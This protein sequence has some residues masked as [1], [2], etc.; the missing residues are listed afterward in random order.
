MSEPQ[1]FYPGS[2]RKIDAPKQQPKESPCT[3]DS[4]PFT[5]W[6]NRKPVEMFAIGAVCS[7]LGRPAV[8]IRLW[9]RQGHLPQAPFKLP[10]NNGVKGR[11]M[12]S[13]KHVELLLDIATKHGI[14]DMPRVDWTKHQ[15]LADEVREAWSTITFE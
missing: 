13:R 15:S 14:V 8:T 7:A 5:K 4:K 11:R 1:E 12:Y 2:R 6:I 3:W 9:I 10:D